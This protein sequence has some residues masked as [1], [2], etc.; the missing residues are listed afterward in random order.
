[1]D[2]R[3]STGS[4][5]TPHLRALRIRMDAASQEGSRLPRLRI[6]VVEPTSCAP[7]NIEPAPRKTA[8]RE[9]RKRHLAPPS[10][11]SKKQVAGGTPTTETPAEETGPGVKGDE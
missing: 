9:R 6:G 4:A 2:D 10:K 3:F 5:S 11:D 8:P 1:L 7:S